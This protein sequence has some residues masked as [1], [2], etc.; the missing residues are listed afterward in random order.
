MIVDVEDV[1]APDACVNEETSMLSSRCISCFN[2]FCSWMILCLI[3]IF[4]EM[5]WME[6]SQDRTKD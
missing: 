2:A 3:F 1:H 6:F 4:I 5:L